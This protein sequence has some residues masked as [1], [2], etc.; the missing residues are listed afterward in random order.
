VREYLTALTI[1]QISCFIVNR[2]FS[3]AISNSQFRISHD[4]IPLSV[5]RDDGGLVLGTVLV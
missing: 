3:I 4:L 1:W 2:N 5:G